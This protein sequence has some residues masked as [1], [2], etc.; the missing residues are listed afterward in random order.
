MNGFDITRD[1]W[2]PSTHEINIPEVT[3]DVSITFRTVS[4]ND[5]RQ[6]SYDLSEVIAPNAVRFCNQYGYA[7]Y[8]PI[9]LVYNDYEIT[10]VNITMDGIDGTSSWWHYSD[11]NNMWVEIPEVTG[12]VVIT[13]RASS[14]Q[15]RYEYNGDYYDNKVEAMVALEYELRT[16]QYTLKPYSNEYSEGGFWKNGEKMSPFPMETKNGQ[17]LSLYNGSQVLLSDFDRV[18]AFDGETFI[19]YEKGTEHMGSVFDIQYGG[20]DVPPF[21]SITQYMLEQN[22]PGSMYN[23]HMDL[24]SLIQDAYYGEDARSMSGNNDCDRF[25]IT[26]FIIYWND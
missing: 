11:K 14:Q 15:E 24:S 18:F 16:G 25:I 5:Y 26:S 20:V 1:C 17:A 19:F 12:D 13:I 21:G 2:N 6:I 10:Y 4:H 23:V 7:L 8:Q 9:Q 22:E 3:G